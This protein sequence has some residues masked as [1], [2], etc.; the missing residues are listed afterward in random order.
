MNQINPVEENFQAQ[1]ALQQQELNAQQN[2]NAG[3]MLQNQHEIQAALIA[4]INPNKVIKEIKLIFEGN[5]EDEL[6]NI[7][8]VSDPLMNQKGINNIIISIKS[9]VNIN[10]IMSAL[11]EKRIND[12]MIDLMDEIIDNLTLN[13]K[14]YE[15]QSKSDLDKIEGIVKRM[16]YPTLMRALRGGERGFLGRVTVEN[17]ST[18]PRLP[19]QKKEG[20]WG[21]FK[22]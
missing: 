22:L 9:I 13:W 19:Q 7:K 10:T 17:I 8:H 1:S 18:A 15:I 11:D 6:G 12:L 2:Q 4:Q 16:A 21:R 3:Y 5:E 14:D 20:F